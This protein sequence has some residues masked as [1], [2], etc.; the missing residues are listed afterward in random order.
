MEFLGLCVV[1][2]IWLAYVYLNGKLD[3]C[4]ARLNVL[5]GRKAYD[6]W[7]FEKPQTQVYREDDPKNVDI[8]ET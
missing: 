2:I 1:M 7:G 6:R 8:E 5:E 4:E 3:D